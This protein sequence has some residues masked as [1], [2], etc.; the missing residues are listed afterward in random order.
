M[1]RIGGCTLHCCE[2]SERS[3]IPCTLPCTHLHP[4]PHPTPSPPLHVTPVGPSE[5]PDT[6]ICRSPRQTPAQHIPTP[7][8]DHS[9]PTLRPTPCPPL[10]WPTPCVYGSVSRL[11][12][13]LSP[14]THSRASSILPLPCEHGKPAASELAKNKA[15]SHPSAQ[16]TSRQ[17][18]VPYPLPPTPYPLPPT[19]SPRRS[20]RDPPSCSCRHHNNPHLSAHPTPP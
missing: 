3:N 17:P 19:L 20:T 16:L 9:P 8:D 18:L 6:S 14:A 15:C 10:S 13:P 2:S 11:S 4:A 7:P 5:L 12:C 1:R